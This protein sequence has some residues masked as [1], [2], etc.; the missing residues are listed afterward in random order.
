MLEMKIPNAA[1]GH[2]AQHKTHAFPNYSLHFLM[3]WAM[4]K[5][6]RDL[7]KK[8]RMEYAYSCKFETKDIKTWSL[9]HK[10]QSNSGG[11]GGRVIS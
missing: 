7:I 11:P 3:I 5:G 10:W 4:V 2:L 8:Y 1:T 9:E 6:F